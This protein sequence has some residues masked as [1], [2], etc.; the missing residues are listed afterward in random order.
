[1][2]LNVDGE[3]IL[4]LLASMA[5]K[6]LLML[7]TVLAVQILILLAVDQWRESQRALR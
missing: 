3:A 4:T 6:T 2:M 1:M 5:A 7:A